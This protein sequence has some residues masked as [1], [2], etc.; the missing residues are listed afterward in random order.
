MNSVEKRRQRLDDAELIERARAGQAD[1]YEHLVRRYQDLAFRVAYV[2]TGAAAEAEEAAQDG[3]V[4][5]YFALPRFRAGAPLRPWLLQI[6]ANEARN[7]RAAAARRFA[8]SLDDG[9][10]SP[11]ETDAGESPEEAALGAERAEQ[12]VACLNDLR[13]EDRQVLTLRYLLDMNEAE[14]A[15]ALGIARGTVK[16]RLSRALGRARA[17]LEARTADV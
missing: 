2:I 14:M 9:Q 6:V 17:A 11:P 12:L 16:S 5:A 13:E 4:K 3:F 1:A 15:S 7:R 8:L 10:A